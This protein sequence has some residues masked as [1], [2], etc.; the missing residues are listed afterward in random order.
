[1][2]LFPRQTVPMACILLNLYN[3]GNCL[4]SAAVPHERPEGRRYLDVSS[5]YTHFEL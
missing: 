5:W 2:S 1:M 4:L 3:G